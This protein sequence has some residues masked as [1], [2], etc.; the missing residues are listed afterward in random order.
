MLVRSLVSRW[1]PGSISYTIP[2]RASDTN[3]SLPRL[4]TLCAHNTD[5]YPLVEHVEIPNIYETSHEI[6]AFT[7]PTFEAPHALLSLPLV[8]ILCQPVCD[9]VVVLC[10]LRH[11]DRQFFGH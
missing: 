5:F 3:V 10:G 7:H 1:C 2:D 8:P 6:D 4:H 9:L 11:A